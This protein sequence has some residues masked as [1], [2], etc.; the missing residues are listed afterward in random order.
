MTHAN[1]P[2]NV[3]RIA[4]L[5]AVGTTLIAST[6]LAQRQQG[7]PGGPESGQQQ[8]QQ[9]RQQQQRQADRAMNQQQT[10]D[11]N[12]L[13]TRERDRTQAPP[14]QSSAKAASKGIF[15]GN[16]MTVEERNQYREQ[17]GK[18]QGDQPRNEFEARHREQ[19]QARARER[20]V[21]PKVTMD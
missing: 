9:M 17:L 8:Q 2:S 21:E 5:A 14:S 6:A 3:V 1:T 12:R 10:A 18:L 20:G 11:H 13:Q 16:L 19:M 7:Q 4:M 15:G